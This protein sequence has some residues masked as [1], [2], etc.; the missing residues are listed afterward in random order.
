MADANAAVGLAGE[1]MK[2]YDGKFLR[3]DVQTIERIEVGGKGSGR[4]VVFTGGGRCRCEPVCCIVI[5]YLTRA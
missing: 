5:T 2:R 1:Q 3:E 4:M